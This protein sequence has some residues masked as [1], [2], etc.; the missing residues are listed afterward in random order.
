MKTIKAVTDFGVLDVKLKRGSADI[1]GHTWV[2]GYV[3]T[4][5]MNSEE[6][7]IMTRVIHYGTG[8]NLDLPGVSFRATNKELFDAAERLLLS[9]GEERVKQELAKYE[10]IN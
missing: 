2:I 6:P 8:R 10:I 9:I 3:P 5:Y 7:L 4:R 1:L